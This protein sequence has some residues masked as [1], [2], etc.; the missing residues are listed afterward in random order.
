MFATLFSAPSLRLATIRRGRGNGYPTLVGS[1][2]VIGDQTE[3][4][5]VHVE[6]QV[7][8]LITNKDRHML[9]TEVGRSSIQAKSRPVRPKT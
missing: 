4:K 8:I 3:P 1:I 5:L 6:S 9:D 2:A 7:S